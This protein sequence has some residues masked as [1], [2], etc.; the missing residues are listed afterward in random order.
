MTP[1]NLEEA[2]KRAPK[3]ALV[4]HAFLMSKERAGRDLSSWHVHPAGAADNHPGW[5]ELRQVL[6]GQ[7]VLR[8][9]KPLEVVTLAFHGC[10]RGVLWNKPTRHPI[11]ALRALNRLLGHPVDQPVYR[12]KECLAGILT[13][14]AYQQ[15]VRENEARIRPVLESAWKAINEDEGKRAKRLLQDNT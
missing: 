5:M 14:L 7:Q 11:T 4:V 13:M 12:P 10:R 15:M 8:R 3:T 9:G 1:E 2:F 6:R